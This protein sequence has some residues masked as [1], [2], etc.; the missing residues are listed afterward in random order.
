MNDR[1]RGEDDG[2][3][4][5]VLELAY[6]SRPVIGK[7]GV[8]GIRRYSGAALL[9]FLLRFS[10]KFIYQKGNVFFPFP[11][12]RDVDDKFAETVIMTQKED[13]GEEFVI[14]RPE[15]WG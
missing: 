11:E 12:R 14:D 3:L 10:Y 4:H 5:A 7:C 8:Q 1:I 9:E 2:P 15:K 6:V 13:A